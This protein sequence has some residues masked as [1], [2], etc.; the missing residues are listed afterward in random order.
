MR[1]RLHRYGAIITASEYMKLE[2]VRQGFSGQRIHVLKL[3]VPELLFNGPEATDGIEVCRRRFVNCASQG[4]ARPSELCLLFVGRM[5]WLKGGQVAIAALP[6]IAAMTGGRAWLNFVGDG[7]ERE[8]WRRQAE[9]VQSKNRSIGFTFDGWLEG[10]ALVERYAQADLLVVPSLWPEPFAMVG[11]E[12]GRYGL[13]AVGFDVGGIRE[14][15]KDNINGHLASANPPTSSGLARTVLEA[16]SDPD[17]YR[18]LC[19]EAL[20]SGWAYDMASHVSAL[21]ELCKEI[22]ARQPMRRQPFGATPPEA[23]ADQV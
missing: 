13:P 18:R 1:T 22:I 17:H 4:S 9:V 14:W 5:E 6:K 23:G 3:P 8:R 12:A 20:R 16:V 21:G 15:L 7:R 19:E 10:A 11:V 2:Y